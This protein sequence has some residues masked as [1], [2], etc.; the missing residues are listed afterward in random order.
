MR[1]DTTATPLPPTIAGF[2]RRMRRHIRAQ[3]ALGGAG[4]GLAVGVAAGVVIALLARIW[5]L[6]LLS[7]LLLLLLLLAVCGAALGALAA[8]LRPLPLTVVAARGDRELGLRER[9]GTALE[10]ATGTAHSTLAPRQL[11]ET[12]TLVADRQPPALVVPRPDRR[13]ALTIAALGAVLALLLV[14]PNPQHTAMEQRNANQQLT[15]AAAQQIAQLQTEVQGR[16][17]LDP[18]TKQAL[19]RQLE[20]LRQDLAS[21]DI[22]RNSAVARIAEVEAQLR[23]LQ[24][25]SVEKR[26]EA[27]PRLAEELTPFGLTADAGQRLAAGDYP[28]AGQALKDAASQLPNLDPASRAALAQKL[29]E[30]AASQAATNPA[31][32]KQFQDA[33]DALEQGDIAGAQAAL[34]GAGDQIAQTGQ[35]VATQQQLGETLGELGAIKRDVANGQSPTT[36]NATPQRASGSP[37]ALNGTPVTLNGQGTPVRISGTPAAGG[38]P[39]I[40]QGQGQ[41]TSQ[42]QGQ[43]AGQGQG[44]GQ[45]QGQGSGS[46]TGGGYSP[47][48]SGSSQQPSGPGSAPQN[49][50]AGQSAPNPGGAY[51][52]V[53]APTLPG[54]AGRQEQIPGSGG[55][56]APPSGTTQGPG[57]NA[58]S[59]VPYNEV[60]EQY[61]DAALSGLDD[62]SIPPEYREYIRQYFSDIDPNK[63]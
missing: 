63:K 49:P 33:A 59:S 56:G 28:G 40:A 46:G 53:Y 60:Y 61:R 12:A 58:P 11:A 38:T 35:Q 15:Q 30:A 25:P 32:A 37:V 13:A 44:S 23:P 29:R 19:E 43:G 3:R 42:G 20:Q 17:D 24:D 31:L 50:A 5:P 10:L 52:S 45:S 54:G 2:L 34:N 39:V 57:A 41:G 14:A 51:E 6:F 22:D 18:E 36:A 8:A 47:D 1:R 48:G 7:Q 27:L 4:Y 62:G 16:N 21:G 55:A 26:A 9:L